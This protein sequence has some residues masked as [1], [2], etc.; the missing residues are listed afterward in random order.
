MG[1][2][3]A[4]AVPR[5]TNVYECAPPALP[6]RGIA[7]VQ[8]WDARNVRSARKASPRWLTLR[9][10]SAGFGKRLAVGGI[11]ED[12]VVAEAA[13]AFRFRRDAALHR[14]ARFEEHAAVLHERKRTDESRGAFAIAFCAQCRVD[15]RELLRIRQ[16]HAAEPR[17]FHARRAV[18]GVNRQPRVLRHREFACRRRV[19]QRLRPGVLLERRARFLRRGNLRPMG[20]RDQCDRRAGQEFTDL[21][22]F[23]GVCRR[24]EESFHQSAVV[25]ESVGECQS[26][27]H[28]RPSTDDWRLPTD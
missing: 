2:P 7:S 26:I 23:V 1:K 8:K 14:S 24:D 6:S 28:R 9:L 12:R 10:G 16:F 11:E 17:R 19:V 20:K 5:F 18:E 3:D 21:A 4:T 13:I 27:L 25:T 15:Q 22:H